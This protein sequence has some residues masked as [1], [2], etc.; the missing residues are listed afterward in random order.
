MPAL[1]VGALLFGVAQATISAYIYSEAKDH[2]LHPPAV[3]AL[4]VFVVGVLA[5]LLLGGIIEVMILE[6]LL[7]AL[8]HVAQ[9]LMKRAPSA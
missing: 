5:A 6:L 2:R 8:Y 9:S 1:G 7:I 4:V 3:P